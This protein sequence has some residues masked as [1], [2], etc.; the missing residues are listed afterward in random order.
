M[1]VSLIAAKEVCPM[2][3]GIIGLPGS[4]KSTVFEALTQAWEE[5]GHK[6]QDRIG[7]VSVPDER[8]NDLTGIFKPKKVVFAQ[9]T[10]FLPQLGPHQQDRVYDQGI[11][12]RIRDCDALIHVVRNFSFPGL[13]DPSPFEDFAR[14][15]QELT[16]NDLIVLENR[17]NHLLA[18]RKRG[19][20]PDEEEPVL[21]KT[22]HRQLETGQ[23]LRKAPELASHGRLRGYA[24]LSAKPM[25]VVFNNGEDDSEPPELPPGSVF[26]E[27]TLAIRGK[28]EQELAQMEE[29]EA[30]QFLSG[31]GI[32][33][34]AARRVI[35]CSYTL[36]GLISFFTVLSDEVRAW[37]L[38][39]G[40][41]ALDA[42]GTIHTDMKK[43][44]I[45]AE[46]IAH[47]D[48]MEVG[49]LP[50]ARKR[51]TVRLEGKTYKVQDGDIIQI[52]F[53][54]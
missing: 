20:K 6:G 27:E 25:L 31:F 40:G 4:G 30:R 33:E 28:I 44:F 29:T 47:K 7:T 32:R 51:G 11:G 50:E 36:L 37:T 3:I 2:K 19:K 52:R 1:G 49:S 9:V 26:S 24:L 45:R 43:G 5:P 42:A 12:N 48:L 16:L 8:L 23:P 18:D 54:V 10:Y 38:K 22:C 39:K 13:P 15:D 46:V 53:N 34:P 17:I 35:R 21:L 41:S 14:L